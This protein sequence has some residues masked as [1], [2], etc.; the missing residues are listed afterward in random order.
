MTEQY[1]AIFSC[2]LAIFV[3]NSLIEKRIAR[4]VFAFFLAVS[5]AYGGV[6]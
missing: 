5:L 3:F 2:V 1:L 4:N 6:I